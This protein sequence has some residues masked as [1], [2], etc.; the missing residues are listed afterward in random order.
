M[1]STHRYLKLFWKYPFLFKLF[2]QENNC[3]F[4]YF[5]WVLGYWRCFCDKAVSGKCHSLPWIVSPALLALYLC[6]VQGGMSLNPKGSSIRDRSAEVGLFLTSTSALPGLFVCSPWSHKQL[7][8]SKIHAAAVSAFLSFHLLQRFLGHKM[9][10]IIPSYRDSLL[11]PEDYLC[12]RFL[13]C[14][15]SHVNIPYEIL[16]RGVNLEGTVLVDIDEKVEM[17]ADFSW[18]WQRCL[19]VVSNSLWTGGHLPALQP[20]SVK[21]RPLLQLFLVPCQIWLKHLGQCVLSV[22]EAMVVLAWCWRMQIPSRHLC[23]YKVCDVNPVYTD[24]AC[25]GSHQQ[26]I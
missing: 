10:L 13:Y 15:R 20:I 4:R 21:K 11:T 22:Y 7:C 19:S 2:N 16:P 23:V 9:Q 17:D 24:V 1:V 5:R 14:S 12:W 3:W 25:T 6:K 18:I 26:K 8:N